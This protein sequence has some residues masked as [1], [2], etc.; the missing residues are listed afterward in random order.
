LA[1]DR[2]K[3]LAATLDWSYGLLSPDEQTIL[4]RLGVF[5]GSFDLP[6]GA[7][8]AGHSG[9]DPDCIFAGILGLAA[10][11]LLVVEKAT[12][13]ARTRYRLL[14]TTRAYALRQLRVTENEAVTR[15]RH[16]EHCLQLCTEAEADW[17]LLPRPEWMALSGRIMGDVRTAIDWCMANGSTTLGLELILAS[18]PVGVQL[19]LVDEYRLRIDAGLQRIVAKR[20]GSLLELQFTTALGHLMQQLRGP[21]PSVLQAF[22]RCL[23]LAGELNNPQLTV[24]TYRGMWVAA[25]G[26]GNYPLAHDY[27]TRQ[28][29]FAEQSADPYALLQAKRMLAQAEH[30]KGEF[31]NAVAPALQVMNDPLRHIPLR[32]NFPLQVDRK[33]SLGII[34]ARTA[35]I[36]GEHAEA[37]RLVE[38]CLGWALADHAIALC[39]ALALAACPI[40][41]WSGDYERVRER[42]E[43]L[44]EHAGRNGSLYWQ[45]WGEMYRDALVYRLDG[46][47]QPASWASLEK[48]PKKVDMLATLDTA[49]ATDM[50]QQRVEEGMVGWCAP[51]VLRARAETQI[52][53]GTPEA[54]IGMLE[55]AAFL[56]R[57]Q[58]ARS[59]MDRI[60]ETMA[61]L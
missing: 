34:V 26:S 35:W 58:D 1:D 38:Q 6:A 9:L 13:G 48:Y 52:R 53:A 43:Q 37:R 8:V 11:S 55:K 56:A 16:A 4:R 24:D 32:W 31:D 42:S 23:E 18:A 49:F 2:H 61:L 7:A 14:E 21:L 60:E 40:A 19:S 17:D 39:H 46:R 33:V 51:E 45:S 22:S 5:T 12:D 25:F 57:K 27:A 30:Y 59:W 3:T 44:I 36:R 10:K 41:F 28:V 54:A 47:P 20:L 15:Q 50:A 29:Q